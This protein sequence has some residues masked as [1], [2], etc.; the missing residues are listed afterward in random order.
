MVAGLVISS[1]MNVKSEVMDGSMQTTVDNLA[2]KLVE[3]AVRYYK[4]R[5]WL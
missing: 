5:G 1:A 3:R 4:K 2:K